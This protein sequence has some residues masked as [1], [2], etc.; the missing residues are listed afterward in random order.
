[1]VWVSWGLWGRESTFWC[2]ECRS[3]TWPHVRDR[4]RTHREGEFRIWMRRCILE[5]CS[6]ESCELSLVLLGT[7]GR[8]YAVH[9]WW[10]PHL[11]WRNRRSWCSWGRGGRAWCR[12][13]GHLW[14]NRRA[15]K[16]Q[17]RICHG[18]VFQVASRS[19]C[20]SPEVGPECIHGQQV[21]RL[22]PW[23]WGG[24]SYIW[25]AHMDISQP[26]SWAL[27]HIELQAHWR[28]VQTCQR[29]HLVLQNSA[30][31]TPFRYRDLWTRINGGWY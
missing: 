19:Q 7:L 16:S 22:P 2:C 11:S 5:W 23:S 17:C 14:D 3:T 15:C 26:L 31:R 12:M 30:H 9:H 18:Q 24:R 4:C 10:F 1:M 28:C 13:D 20:S 27:W 25:I 21:A 29:G 8:G 6:R